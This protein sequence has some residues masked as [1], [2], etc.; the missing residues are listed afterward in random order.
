MLTSAVSS[1]DKEIPT[2]MNS[3]SALHNGL[4]LIN[5]E[6]ASTSDKLK[7]VKETYFDAAPVIK[8]IFNLIQ[9]S[10]RSSKLFHDGTERLEAIKRENDQLESSIVSVL[11]NI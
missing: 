3:I 4:D 10:T 9:R 8:I 2:A 5:K 7:L 11:Y 1:R 6:L